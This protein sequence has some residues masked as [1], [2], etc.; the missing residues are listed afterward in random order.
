MKY[1]ISR[2]SFKA[3][4]L[5]AM[6]TLATS[7]LM[8]DTVNASGDA[9]DTEFKIFKPNGNLHPRVAPKKKAPVSDKKILETFAVRHDG[10][11]GASRNLVEARLNST[12]KRMGFGIVSGYTNYSFKWDLNMTDEQITN[13]FD[14]VTTSFGF[15]LNNEE[16]AEFKHSEK[17]ITYVQT[18]AN[19]ICQQASAG[20]S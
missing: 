20:G 10:I 19:S 15:E 6:V 9:G 17:F 4:L 11:C 8:A 1:T 5:L 3:I 13:A 12:L 14:A 2:Q 18:R 7:Q 16:R